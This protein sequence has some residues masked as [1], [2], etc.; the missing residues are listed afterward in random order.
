MQRLISLCAIAALAG[1]SSSS[2]GNTDAGGDL[3][4][5]PADA[6]GSDFARPN[7]AAGGDTSIVAGRCTMPTW[8][9]S[10]AFQSFS[11]TAG[12]S[13]PQASGWG[14]FDNQWSCSG[15]NACLNETV[16][17]CDAGSWFVTSN[18][19]A[20]NT[21]VLTYTST[22]VNFNQVALSTFNAITSTFSEVSPHDAT[23]VASSFGD[24]EAAYDVFFGP[25]NDNEIMVWVDNNGQT[26]GGGWNAQKSSVTIGGTVF[27]VYFSG[28]TTYWVAQ[29]NFTSGTIDLLAIFK[30]TTGTLHNFDAT[31]AA[32]Y[33]NQIQ[34]GWELCSTNGAAE[35]FYL[36]AFTVSAS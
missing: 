5:N 32:G 34:F 22:Q 11:P 31:Q 23:G 33:L 16:H 12:S 20:G 25:N 15:G 18:L 3:A 24:Y 14:V 36:D 17:V 6:S 4:M 30:Y 28:S 35:T 13:T 9:G 7:D 21:A 19:P 8:S 1:C 29:K 26:P 2:P 10:D 27:D